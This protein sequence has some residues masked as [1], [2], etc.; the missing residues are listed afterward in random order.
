MQAFGWILFFLVVTILLAYKRAALTVWTIALFVFLLLVSFFSHMSLGG[1]IV[2]WILFAILFIPLNIIPLR[3]KLITER[4]M[5][6]YRK[7]M[8]P[9]SVTEKEALT[10]GGVGWEGEIFTG[11]PDWQKL[12]QLPEIKLTQEE[13]E[14]IA[15]P[16]EELCGLISNWDINHVEREI[17]EAIWEHLKKHGFL[18]LIIPKQYGGK[19]FSALAHTQIITKVA[20]VSI[21]VGCIVSVPNSLGPAE[22]LLE[23]G[24]E[25]QK[26]YYLPRLARG[27]EIPCF[28]LTSPVAGSDASSIEDH[29]VVCKRTIDGKE[30]LG[31]LLNWNKRYITLSPIATLLG[32]AFKLYDP[33]HLLG[34][35]TQLG[36]TCALIPV[37][38]SGVV[39]GRRHF[40]LCSHFP[41][42]P[43]QGKDVFIP[44]DYVI[45]GPSMVGAGWR[46][47]MECLAA[48]RSISLPSM[49][50]GGGKRALY[51]TGAYARI[52]RQ[53]NTYIGTFGGVQEALARI[54]GYTYLIEALRLF[55]V[56]SIDRGVKSAV[57]SAITKYHVTEYGRHIVN[58]AMDVSG[59]KGICMGPHNYLAQSYI[60]TP[61][62]I[63]VEGANILTRSMIIFG[64][65]AIRCHPYI[66]KE[67]NAAQLPD[68]HEALRAFD[69]VFFKHMGM[70]ISN[71]T[72]AFC[73]GLTG[74]YGAGAPQ[75]E[76]KHRYQQFSRY[77]SA[78]AYIADIAMLT[79]GGKLK[80]KERLSA[81]LGDML[82]YLYMGSAVLRYHY[83][84]HNS[85]EIPV[86]DWIC[87][88][89]VYQ[90]QESLHEFLRN[91]P[92]R[93]LA[94]YLRFIVFPTGRWNSLPT[95]RL[96]KKLATLTTE[97]SSVRE[98]V[99]QF[100][101]T[102]RG[103]YDNPIAGIQNALVKS[104]EAEPLLLR[105]HQAQRK[106]EIQGMT[107]AEK[108]ASAIETHVLSEAEGQQLMEA[109]QLRL[110]IINVDDFSPEDFRRTD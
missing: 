8:P 43:T 72:R 83:E 34:D 19:G 67:M 76:L 103:E 25:Q 84:G 12:Q 3:R 18:G 37:T 9:M 59:G 104:I 77:A 64:Q 32:L 60:E 106:N 4:I 55:S 85:E 93:W 80:R 56:T 42:G 90:L 13:Q 50:T 61:I 5:S 53:F 109:E 16:V 15:G 92:N 65:G 49:S 31:I 97:S 23:Y 107:F 21:A 46:M 81:R 39:T 105:L 94:G 27:E 2:L 58:D 73:L 101:Y 79:L 30:T 48:G 74:G 29:G 96:S 110:A 100:L 91:L 28:A 44:L 78:F 71:K 88:Y 6:V 57:S 70:I 82:S 1:K 36:I 69:H 95:D 63:T 75:G 41:N 68:K 47:L 89:L 10:A 35:K 40:P 11:M 22:L 102:Q 26:N 14:F 45:G 99:C 62:S 54:M 86:V 98:R 51:A 24:T 52:R 108:V 66:L 87:Q 33:D 7:A 20:G 17:P 38:T